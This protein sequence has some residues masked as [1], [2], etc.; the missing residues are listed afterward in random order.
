M[1]LAVKE[2]IRAISSELP[3]GFLEHHHDAALDDWLWTC[4]ALA[5]HAGTE[6]SLRLYEVKNQCRSLLVEIL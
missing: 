4:Y 6:T 5:L 1:W 3:L 2:G